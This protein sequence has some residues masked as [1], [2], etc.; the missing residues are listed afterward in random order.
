MKKLA[1][2]NFFTA[3][4]MLLVVPM[5]FFSGSAQ[6][7]VYDDFTSPGINTSLWVDKGPNLGLFSQP[8]DSYLYFQDLS[9]G[10]DDRIRSYNQVSGAFSVLMRYSNFQAVNTQPPGQGKSTFLSLILADGINSVVMMEGKNID[11]YFFQAQFNSSGNTTPLNYFYPGYINNVWLGIRYN[12][13]LG[14]GGKVDFLYNFGDRWRVIDSY[15]PNFSQAPWFSIRGSDLYG[16]SLSFQIDQV[17]V[18]TPSPLPPIYMLLE[19]D[20]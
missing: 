12:G 20:S 7:Y 3:L 8:G 6:A 9:G 11:G 16:Q 19:P 13:V 17:Q 14:S 18:T 1:C 4:F 15:A 5:I 10:L 2:L